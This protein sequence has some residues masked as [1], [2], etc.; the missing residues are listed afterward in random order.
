MTFLRMWEGAVKWRFRDFLA[1]LDTNLFNF[2]FSFRLAFS[3]FPARSEI[4]VTFETPGRE[5]F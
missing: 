5:V 4:A 3:Y 2:I 1:E